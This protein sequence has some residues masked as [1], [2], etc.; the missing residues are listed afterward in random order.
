MAGRKGRNQQERFDLA[1]KVCAAMGCKRVVRYVDMTEKVVEE[2]ERF[3][4]RQSLYG[5]FTS[6]AKVK[7]P[8]IVKVF[9]H[10]GVF[11]FNPEVI[12]AAK[13][14]KR[15]AKDKASQTGQSQSD[16][17]AVP[18]VPS[19][20]PE[21]LRPVVEGLNLKFGQLQAEV[22]RTI[23][24]LQR[25]RGEQRLAEARRY[26]QDRGFTKEEVDE[27]SRDYTL[28]PGSKSS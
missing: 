8:L 26:L 5:Y 16:A 7:T 6:E 27:L 17:P 28:V 18:S 22:E 20:I 23:Q 24:Q 21:N 12:A 11:R 15:T 3:A 2:V 25:E 9:K 10:K 13:V 14:L 19:G 1:V 4:N